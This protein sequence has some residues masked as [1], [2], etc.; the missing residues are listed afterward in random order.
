MKQKTKIYP[1][2]AVQCLRRLTGKK[3]FEIYW[4]SKSFVKTHFKLF[5]Y[6]LN[7]SKI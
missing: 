3:M 6:Y 5:S 2:S 1:P 4:S 7:I